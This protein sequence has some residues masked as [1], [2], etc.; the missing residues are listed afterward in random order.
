MIFGRDENIV[1]NIL[2][3]AD[4]NE[5]H[6]FFEALLSAG[7]AKSWQP[8]IFWGNSNKTCKILVLCKTSN[9]AKIVKILSDISDDWI[10]TRKQQAQNAGFNFY[11]TPTDSGFT[12]IYY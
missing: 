1:C 9:I 4:T 5:D 12:M 3:I 11:V 7:E 6:A 10:E 2:N 8:V